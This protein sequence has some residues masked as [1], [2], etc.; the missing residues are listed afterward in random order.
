M[1]KLGLPINIASVYVFYEV[2]VAG[3]LAFNI[4]IILDHLLFEVLGLFLAD[5][6]QVSILLL[7][8]LTWVQIRLKVVFAQQAKWLIIKR[9]I[10][11]HGEF[12][13]IDVTVFVI[14]LLFLIELIFGRLGN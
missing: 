7:L 9:L 1:L 6:A 14:I 2:D 4:N 10:S 5:G 11:K 3:E 13:F 12:I 8:M